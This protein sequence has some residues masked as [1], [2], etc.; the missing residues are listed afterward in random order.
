MNNNRTPSL[1]AWALPQGTQEEV[2]IL[3]SANGQPS[4][5]SSLLAL[6]QEQHPVLVSYGVLPTLPKRLKKAPKCMLVL[7][8]SLKW[9][10]LWGMQLR[11]QE[12]L[13]RHVLLSSQVAFFWVPTGGPH[14]PSHPKTWTSSAAFLLCA[15]IWQ[16]LSITVWAKDPCSRS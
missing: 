13:D 5:H 11:C 7:C 1:Y 6:R 16:W 9:Q 12:A 14:S 3:P 8:Q 15:A 10:I 2:L 4:T